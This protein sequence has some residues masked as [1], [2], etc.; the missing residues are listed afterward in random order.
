VR[1][2]HAPRLFSP[3]VALW[4]AYVEEMGW[5]RGRSVSAQF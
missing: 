3:R 5:L 4:L 2:V 1:G